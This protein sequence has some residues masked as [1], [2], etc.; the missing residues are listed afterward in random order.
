MMRNHS[1]A[2]FLLGI[3]QG[4]NA[5]PALPDLQDDTVPVFYEHDYLLRSRESDYWTLSEYYFPQ[6]T[7]CGCSAASAAMALNA[8]RHRL[9][10][11]EPALDDQSLL[12]AV[13]DPVWMERT[14]ED[15]GGVTL[16]DLEDSIRTALDCLRID[17]SV[18]TLGCDLE[19]GALLEALREALVRNEASPDSVMLAYY[20]QSVVTGDPEGGLHV[21]P[22]GAFNAEAD[23]VLLMDV[24]QECCLPYWTSTET[25]LAALTTPD[26][27]ED[28]LLADQAGGCLVISAV[29]LESFA[30]A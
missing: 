11:D 9:D 14:A 19:D 7:N 6:T 18:H 24:D 29:P 26:P 8:L 16:T 27:K 17:G 22:I 5:A 28:G 25:L 1:G 15:G 2:T 21:S 30:S 20:N 13:S 4:S 23:R 3:A 10:S 12:A